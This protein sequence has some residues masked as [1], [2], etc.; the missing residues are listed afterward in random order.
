MTLWVLNTVRQGDVTHALER[1]GVDASACL[2]AVRET[3]DPMQAMYATDTAT[4]S[5]LFA[6]I[7]PY[8]EDPAQF[9]ADLRALAADLAR[10]GQ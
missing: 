2:D 1:M 5:Y 9:K 8:A 10:I 6:Q 3:A 7:T 4:F